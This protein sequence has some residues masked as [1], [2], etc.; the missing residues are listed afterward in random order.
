LDVLEKWKPEKLPFAVQIL[1]TVVRMFRT[2]P[3]TYRWRG[4][5]NTNDKPSLTG[6]WE[7][8]HR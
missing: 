2:W 5:V 7:R 4:T 1:T 3:P 8:I 6:K